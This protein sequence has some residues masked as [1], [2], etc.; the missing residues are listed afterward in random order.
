MRGKFLIAV[1]TFGLWVSF[2]VLWLQNQEAGK[3]QVRIDESQKISLKTSD[4][5]RGWASWYG[6]DF[7]GKKMANGKHYDMHK[8]SV[9]H[10]SLPLGTKVKVVNLRNN[11]S[12]IALVSDRGPYACGREI[13]L[14]YAAAK[15]LG[16]VRDGVIPVE[17]EIR[18]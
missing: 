10:Q 4:A 15:K 12:I 3:H 14:S 2:S 1:L 8:V 18:I 9:A 17:I 13:D 6:S 11:K 16:A 5:I 7:Q